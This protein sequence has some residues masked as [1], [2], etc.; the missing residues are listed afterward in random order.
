M[1][2]NWTWASRSLHAFLHLPKE[3]DTSSDDLIPSHSFKVCPRWGGNKIC[4]ELLFYYTSIFSLPIHLIKG[5]GAPCLF[6][7]GE[8]Q[9]PETGLSSVRPGP[10]ASYSYSALDCGWSERVHP[11]ELY[12][13]H[14]CADNVP[15][16][17]L[18][19]VVIP[20]WVP[21][22]NK[23]WKKTGMSVGISIPLL[24]PT[25]FLRGIIGPQ[26]P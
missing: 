12:T 25:L 1:V 26:T 24:I 16:T 2:P 20:S 22:L 3:V 18:P 6:N 21:S 7:G 14:S 13:L 17:P 5:A 11:S 4:A 10:Q 15:L 9:T 8:C 19:R 23:I